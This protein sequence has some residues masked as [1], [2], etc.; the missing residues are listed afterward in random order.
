MEKNPDRKHMYKSGIKGKDTEV[1]KRIP[2]CVITK[3][4]L[5]LIWIEVLIKR[6][7]KNV[8]KNLIQN[9]HPYTKIID[10]E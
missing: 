8:C 10:Y 2:S 5:W 3:P 9:N 1:N 4:E 7:H 6:I